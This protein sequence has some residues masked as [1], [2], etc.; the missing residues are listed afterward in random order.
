MCELTVRE[1]VRQALA[2][3]LR[4]DEKVFLLGEDI[5]KYGGS[6][7]VTQGLYEEFGPERVMDAPIVENG[8]SNLAVGAALAG[9]RPVVEYMFSDFVTVAMDAIANQAAKLRFMLGGQV[10]VPVVFRA[11]AGSGTGAAAQHSQ[12]LEAWFCHLPGLYVLAP[13]QP[14]DAKGLLKAA[15]R[16]NSPVLFLEHK[17]GY[18]VSGE[19]PDEEEVLPI[20]RAEVK[21]PGKDLT[22]ISY[23]HTLIKCLKAAEELAWEGIDAEVLDLRTLSP[24]DTQAIIASAKKTGRVLVVHEAVERFGVGAEVSAL[25][26]ESDAFYSLKKPV[27]RLGGASMPMP[28]TPAL[29][30]Q[31]IPQ[32]ENI[33]QCARELVKG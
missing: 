21:R 31:A 29:E 6:F 32:V 26:H 7:G 20:G 13:S 1:A 30:A 4:R 5:G 25:I 16:C 24:L 2:E 19:V 10:E 9:Y 14:R 15:I 17:L 23:S 18:D 3:E 8:F 12:S 22:L 33:C 11:P 27:K 28:F